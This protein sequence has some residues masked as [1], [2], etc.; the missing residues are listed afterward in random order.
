MRPRYGP[1]SWPHLTGATVRD[2][3]RAHHTISLTT[4]GSKVAEFL[5]ELVNSPLWV[6]A[7]RNFRDNRGLRLQA[8]QVADHATRKMTENTR[9]TNLG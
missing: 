5:G 7:I 6:V 2:V 8:F 4:L 9:I 3:F 1:Q